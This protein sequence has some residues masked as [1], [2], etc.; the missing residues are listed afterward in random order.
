MST[1]T[2]LYMRI[3]E[4]MAD[5]AEVVAM[6]EKEIARAAKSAEKTADKYAKA[7][8]VMKGHAVEPVCARDLAHE[9]QLKY[10]TDERWTTQG[11]SYYLRRMVKEGIVEEA[12]VEDSKVKHYIY[13][14]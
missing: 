4:K 12:A 14:G 5:D 9:I 6:C 7:L 3:I 13:A 11:A 8:S 2:R 1:R 10:G